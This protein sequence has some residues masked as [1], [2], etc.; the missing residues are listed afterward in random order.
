[1]T[2]KGEHMEG[3]KKSI[4]ESIVNEI[5]KKI[6][7]IKYGSITITIHNSKIVQT[8]IAEKE[9]YENAGQIEKGGG[10]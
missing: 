7:N 8:E 2:T 1:M 10:I 3:N 9:R 6:R 4:N 5:A